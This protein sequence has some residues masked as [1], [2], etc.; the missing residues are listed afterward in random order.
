MYILL[1]FIHSFLFFFSFAS[2]DKLSLFH[3]STFLQWTHI[4]PCFLSLPGRS[5]FWIGS[6]LILTQKV[7][8]CEIH[9][10]IWPYTVRT[11]ARLTRWTLELMVTALYNQAKTSDQQTL[12]TS[13]PILPS[14]KKSQ[15]LLSKDGLRLFIVQSNI[16]LHADHLHLSLPCSEGE[17]LLDDYIWFGLGYWTRLARN[18]VTNTKC[19]TCESSQIPLNVSLSSFW[20]IYQQLNSLSHFFLLINLAYFYR[21][22]RPIS[23]ELV[24]VSHLTDQ[25]FMR[26]TS[27]HA[28]MIP[29]Y[30]KNW[31]HVSICSFWFI[32]IGSEFF[33][34]L[35]IAKIDL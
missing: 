31:Y 3:W 8:V 17:A 5:P 10:V 15:T 25:P 16:F 27:Q 6:T 33:F 12:P 24:S 26:I 14:L 28:A 34:H 22:W 19:P 30:I 2:P 23:W 4:S 20:T 35:G 11:R 18:S 29:G 1:K 21:T 7:S 9:E 32:V 13:S